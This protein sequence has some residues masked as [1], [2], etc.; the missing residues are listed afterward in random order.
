MWHLKTRAGTFWVVAKPV[1]DMDE[2]KYYLG[3]NDEELGVYDDLNK[4]A[5]DVY[6]QSTGFFKWDCQS[7][8]KAPSDISQWIQGEPENWNS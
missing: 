7:K 6:T 2:H 1:S 8:V 4:A 5:Q 3:V